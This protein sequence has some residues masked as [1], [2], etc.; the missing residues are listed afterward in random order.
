MNDLP[1]MSS[2]DPRIDLLPEALADLEDILLYTRLVF[3]P[4]QASRYLDR[5]D[6]ALGNLA[7][8]P[9]MG[10]PRSVESPEQRVFP[11]AEHLIWYLV[12]DTTIQIVAITHG[13]S[14]KQPFGNE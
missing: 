12:R 2:P 1:G 5:L 6:R 7:S 11:V 10:R 3:G 9:G 13:Q 14:E 4:E 8:Y